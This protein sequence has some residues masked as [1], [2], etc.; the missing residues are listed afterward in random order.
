MAEI[1]TSI[2][3]HQVKPANPLE[4][5]SGITGLQTQM[6]QNKLFQQQFQTNRAVSDI[7][8][9]AI[10][11]DGTI[12]PQKLNSLLATDPNA[13][14]G[15]PQAYQGSQEAQQRN[16]GIEQTQ[17][18]LAR[19]NMQTAESYLSPLLAHPNPSSSEIVGALSEAMTKGHL[20][21]DVAMDLFS[22]LPRGPDGQI[23]ETKIT[24]WLKQQQMRM[25]DMKQR[26][27]AM[28]P[29]P[30]MVNNGQAQI[31]VR[32]PQI[33]EPSQAGPAIQNQLPPTTPVF[34]PQTNAP[35]YLGASGGGGAQ[36][37]QGG[38]IQS[39]PA[40]GA[41]EAAS[42]DASA[43]ANQGV[44]LQSEAD[45]VP[46]QK[47][48]LGNLEGALDKFEPGPGQG[49]K[50]EAKKFA[51]L[52]NPFGQI[53]N[54]ASIASQEEFNKQATQLAQAQFKTLGGTGTDSKLD[55]AMHT[56]PNET[57][58]KM[59]NKGIIAMLK[60]NVDAIAAKNQAWQQFKQAHGPQSYGQFS[61]EFNKTYDPRVFQSQYLTVDDRKKMLSGMTKDEQ[62]GF[63]GAYRKALESG[64]V[65]LPGA[66]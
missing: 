41:A 16:L 37:G 58:S 9:Q 60:G 48:L 21:Q 10:K 59:G 65:K 49:W 32:L 31:P 11:P 56:S 20:K 52:N 35:G 15:L 24:P 50:N 43:S 54:P 12:D 38:G 1:D 53:F 8:K 40:L 39:G 29:A 23:D 28:Y 18:D 7:Y 5:L 47:A 63:I 33:G 25:M 26:F 14:Y 61:T 30:T 36:G 34:N 46:A 42:V 57:L 45:Q 55:S 17:I 19:K 6:N 66:K 3:Q 27:D 64:W 51:N 22:S 13:S 44:Q 4:T 62:K 2:Y